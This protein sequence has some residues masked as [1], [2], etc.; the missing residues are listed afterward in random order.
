VFSAT[1]AANPTGAKLGGTVSEQANQ[2]LATFSG[3]TLSKVG[4]GYTLQLSNKGLASAITS[5]ITV[6]KTPS[7]SAAADMGVTDASDPA[8]APVILGSLDIVGS[9]QPKKHTFAI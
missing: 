6:T 7:G 8:G 4:S 2:G 3:L 5:S 9:L 1:L